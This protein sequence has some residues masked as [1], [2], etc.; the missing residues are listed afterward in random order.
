M[1]KRKHGD[2]SLDGVYTQEFFPTRASQRA[3]RISLQNG[4]AQRNTVLPLMWMVFIRGLKGD[5]SLTP[6]PSPASS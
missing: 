5:L 2:G 6:E 1:G 4:S 3:E